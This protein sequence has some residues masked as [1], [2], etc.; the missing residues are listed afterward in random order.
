MLRSGAHVRM[1]AALR[2]SERHAIRLEL[3][4][5]A[6]RLRERS[7]LR[8]GCP[9][10]GRA[11]A[12]SSNKDMRDDLLSARGTRRGAGDACRG[13]G[14]A[15]ASTTT[16]EDALV[17]TLIAAARLHVE[18]VTGRALMRRAG[19]WCSTAGRRPVVRCRC[20]RVIAVTHRRLPMR[21]PRSRRSRCRATRAAAA[22]ATAPCCATLSIDRL[23]RRLW[24]GGDD[25]PA[26]S[27]AGAA[28]AGRLLVRA[29]RRGVAATVGAPPGFDRL[30]AP[31]PRGCGCERDAHPADRHADRPRAAASAAITTA[32]GRGRQHRVCSRR[33]RRCGRGCARC[34]RG[35]RSTATRAARAITPFGGAALSHRPRAGRPHRLSRRDARGAGGRAISTGGGPISACQCSAAGGDG[36]THPIL[37]CRSTLVAALRAARAAAL[38]GGVRCAAGGA[39]AALCGDRPAR[40]A[41]ARRRCGARPRAPAAAP[42]LGRR[43]EPQGGGWRWPSAWWRSG[44]RAPTSTARR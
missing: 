37:P 2:C 34:R 7:A 18:S 40:C 16:D 6:C 11:G 24:R 26:G 38:V 41:A 35:R 28:D 44:A 22:A 14:L 25:V 30:V 4:D 19:G 10:L 27:E 5:F 8:R 39:R 42:R 43:C 17:A 3:T 1:Y 32:R 12:H 15:A 36:M 9:S 21:R 13:Q 29:P 31:L 20:C 33:S 23:C